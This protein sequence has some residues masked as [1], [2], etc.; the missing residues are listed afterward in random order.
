[1]SY[2]WFKIHHEILDDPKIGMMCDTDQLIWFK[3]LC[4]AS[5]DKCRGTVTLTDDEIAFKLRCSSETW[6]HAKDKF[7]AKGLIEPI[8]NAI[9]ITNWEKRQSNQKPSDKP[10][11]T[12]ERK[13]K[14]RAKHAELKE[15]NNTSVSRHVTPPSRESHATDLDLDLD[16]DLDQKKFIKYSLSPLPPQNQEERERD[17]K[18]SK[19]AETPQ[20]TALSQ[21]PQEQK[22]KFLQFCEKHYEANNNGKHLALP[23]EYAK[24][25]FDDLYYQFTKSDAFLGFTEDESKERKNALGIMTIHSALD[26]PEW[27][28][29]YATLEQQRDYVV[30]Q[31]SRKS[32]SKS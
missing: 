11:A 25:Y 18:I 24:R 29:K 6:Q 27:V 4:L 14:Q 5:A 13:R 32:A 20:A 16:L 22:E 21:L 15:T 7:R 9:A 3:L 1:M 30:A 10:E 12:R 31:N 28:L 19:N 23:Q 17:F 2:T 8:E 26:W